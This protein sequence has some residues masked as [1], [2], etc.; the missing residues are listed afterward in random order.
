MPQVFLVNVGAN[1][2]HPLKSPLFD[3]NS[4]ELLPIP[5]K[6]PHP[7][8][9]MVCYRDLS[10]WTQP[11]KDLRAYVPLSYWERDCHYDPEFETC[12]YGD[13]PGRSPRAAALRWARKGDLLLFLARLWAWERDRFGDKSG[14][15]LVG[16]LEVES[17]LKD[18]RQPLVEAVL[19][20]FGAN[21]HIRRA[22][23][24][25]SYWNGFWV[26]KGSPRSRR[27]RRALELTPRL[28]EEVLRDKDGQPWVWRPHRTA[29]QTIGSYTR[30]VRCIA[31]TESE[32]FRAWPKELRSALEA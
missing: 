11:G 10:S 27:F 15:Y 25:P 30:T 32:A 19:A 4:F 20:V 17:V 12:T 16:V 14:F 13:D 9:S 1:A 21:A 29:L 31:D 7:G 3:D 26:Y 28:A 22:Q 18:V 5:E 6:E 8:S 23:A 2:S 24:D